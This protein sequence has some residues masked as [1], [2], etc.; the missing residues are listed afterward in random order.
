MEISKY[1][2]FN[3]ISQDIDKKGKPREYHGP[4]YWNYGCLPQTWEDP[5]IVHEE[6]KCHGDK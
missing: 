4:I 5:D 3:P 1:E 2:E 6:L